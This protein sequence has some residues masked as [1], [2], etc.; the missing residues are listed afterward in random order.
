MSAI[1]S[2]C[3]TYRYRLERP[4]DFMSDCVIAY[5]GVNPSTAD[6]AIDDPTVRRWIGFTKLFGGSRFIVGYVFAYRSTD[7]NALARAADPVGPDNDAHLS[8]IIAEA[9]VLVPCWGPRTKVP[10]P[11]R[12][13]FDAVEAMLRVGKKPVM[14]F[15]FSKDG[16]PLHPL[17]LAYSTPLVKWSE[18]Q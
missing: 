14:A 15:G 16:D 7:V 17:M 18:T 12:P 8:A 6:A 2:A 4:I 11:L 5:F 13:R 10:A 1:L 9:D 3:G